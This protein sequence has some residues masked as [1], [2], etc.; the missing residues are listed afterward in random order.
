MENTKEGNM[1]RHIE[2]VSYK[3]TV[4]GEIKSGK[5]PITVIMNSA[6]KDSGRLLR[7]LI[8]QTV[9]RNPDLFNADVRA[10]AKRR[11]V[12]DWAHDHFGEEL[13]FNISDTAIA[14]AIV[15]IARL[16]APP[17]S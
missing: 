13:A 14:A 4:E 3:T 11:Q 1:L 9:D 7:E 5:E 15:E 10:W 8:A 17:R 16:I 12:P 2:A 6:A